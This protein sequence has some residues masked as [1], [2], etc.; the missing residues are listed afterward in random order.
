MALSFFAADVESPA[1][2]VS[3][4]AKARTAAK[5]KWDLRATSAPI[6]VRKASERDF[7]AIARIQIACLEAAQWPVGD[8]SSF[9][10]LL[11]LVEGQPAGFLAWRQTDA[12]EAEVLNL[13][14]HPAWRRRGVGSALLEA[15]REAASGDVFLEVAETNV[16]AIALYE[17]N[18]WVRV[19]LRR[20]YYEKG[21]INAVVMK[22]SSC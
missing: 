2:P 11:A 18:G 15:V 21:R 5:A 20:G 9:G 13:G 1:L 16:E 12:Q 3:R 7:P 19:A 6:V 17:R 22:K 10:M 4:W 14:V 8:Y